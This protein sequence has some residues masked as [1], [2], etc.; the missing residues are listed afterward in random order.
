MQIRRGITLA[1]GELVVQRKGSTGLR[2][3][4]CSCSRAGTKLVTKNMSP[5][6]VITAK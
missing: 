6:R 1:R 5:R 3:A 2:R 4:G